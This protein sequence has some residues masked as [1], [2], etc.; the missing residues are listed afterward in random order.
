MSQRIM[1]FGTVGLHPEIVIKKPLCFE[2]SLPQVALHSK[3]PIK[4]TMEF[5]ENTQSFGLAK[6]RQVRVLV[7]PH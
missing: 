4:L 3:P 6:N 2:S 1:T 5:W 7:A